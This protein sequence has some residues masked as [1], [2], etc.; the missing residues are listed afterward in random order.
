MN[1]PMA[2]KGVSQALEGTF[3][4]RVMSERRVFDSLFAMTDQKEELCTFLNKRVEAFR[5]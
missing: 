1:V 4:D 2:K 5:Q 3:E